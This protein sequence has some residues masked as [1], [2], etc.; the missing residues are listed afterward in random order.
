M[1][2]FDTVKHRRGTNSLKWDEW[3]IPDNCLPMWVADMDFETAPE[4][5]EAIIKRASNGIFGY[6]IV[7]DRWQKAISSW[8]EL[9]YSY[10]IDP[11][12]LIFCTGVIP[13]I[14]SIV[15]KL[16]TPN[17]NVVIMTPVYNIFFNSIINNG[18]RVLESPLK[19]ING[20]YEP[21]FDDL[22]DK[23]SD[24]QTSLMILCNPQNPGGRIWS[25]DEL[26][27][28]G[29]LC[30][31]YDVTV[32]S[33]EIHCDL[34]DPGRTYVPFASVSE[35]CRDISVTCIAPTKTFNIAGLQSAAV[36][37]YNRSLRHRVWRG[38]NTDEVAE[39]NAFAIDAAIAAY[40]NGEAWLEELRK[41]IF[42][43]KR[44]V[45]EY[46]AENI[47]QVKVTHSDATYLLWL[48]TAE[49]CEDSHDLQEHL[50]SSA[51]LY[52]SEGRIYG[53]GGERFL[54]MNIACPRSVLMEGL[55]RLKKGVD[56]YS[57]MKRGDE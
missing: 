37:A 55:G 52:L 36:F 9:R 47:P 31:R 3:D 33:D 53:A 25:R 21:D 38:L 49:V 28:I 41:Y 18:A 4:I 11:E 35:I 7:P 22:E 27:R 50:K 56:S 12:H 45:I 20:K 2:D 57:Q 6:S 8:W 17:E 48:Y 26:S 51:G 39:P 34:T 15:R 42:E 5:K 19:Y 40:E 16:T 44:A 24:P 14:S 46:M 10:K 13:A 23:L 29:E 43:N 54:R 1:Y 32:I 30:K